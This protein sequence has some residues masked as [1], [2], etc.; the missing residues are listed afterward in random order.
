[1]NKIQEAPA[2]WLIS[3]LLSDN[4]SHKNN[5]KLQP[6]KILHFKKYR[7]KSNSPDNQKNTLHGI[8]V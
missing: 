5:K 2:V 7:A 6:D 4:F 3:G 1:M 8:L